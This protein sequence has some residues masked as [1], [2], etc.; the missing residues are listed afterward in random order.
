MPLRGVGPTG[1]RLD[2]EQKS[3]SMDGNEFVFVKL[4]F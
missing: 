1:R 3:L 4:D 2:F